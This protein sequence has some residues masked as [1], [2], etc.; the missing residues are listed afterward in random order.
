MGFNAFGDQRVITSN[1]AVVAL[2]AGR[3]AWRDTE[4]SFGDGN[5]SLFGTLYS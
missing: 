3:Q 4:R 1:P 5:F 2:A